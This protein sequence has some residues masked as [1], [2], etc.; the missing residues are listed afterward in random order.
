M[1]FLNH[2]DDFFNLIKEEI[3]IFSSIIYEP[4]QG[5]KE[6]LKRVALRSGIWWEEEI[7]FCFCFLIHNY[8]IHSIWLYSITMIKK[9]IHISRQRTTM[10]TT[11]LDNLQKEEM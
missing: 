7:F 11:T 3:S 10:E 5:K 4:H 9:K 8:T 6:K 1:S 2:I